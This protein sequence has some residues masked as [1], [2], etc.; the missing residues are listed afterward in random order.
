[1]VCVTSHIPQLETKLFS[2]HDLYTVPPVGGSA[3]SGL[4][5]AIKIEGSISNRFDNC[6]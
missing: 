6:T 1:M 4:N 2:P 5:V 3:M